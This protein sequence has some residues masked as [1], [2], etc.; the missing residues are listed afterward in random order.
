MLVLAAGLGI[1]VAAAFLLY[2]FVEMS[3]QKWSSAFAYR[4]N[5]SKKTAV[6]AGLG[7]LL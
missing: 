5:L 4:N 7:M 2:H 3:A 1:S 6:K